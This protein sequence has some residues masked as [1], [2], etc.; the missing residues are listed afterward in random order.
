MRAK[1]FCTALSTV[2]LSLFVFV[3]GAQAGLEAVYAVDG[4]FTAINA[5]ELDAASALFAKDAVAGYALTDQS[6]EGTDKIG[7]FL[8]E[9]HGERREYEIVQLAMVGDT[10]NLTVDIA[11]SGHVW[12][13]AT[14]TVEVQDG[15]IQSL[16]VIETRLMLWRI[17]G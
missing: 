7:T 13:Q 16:E 5:G 17:Q 15:M 10:V 1:A 4:L 9:L 14:L 3:S 12:G 2:V 8:D 11:D 6:Y